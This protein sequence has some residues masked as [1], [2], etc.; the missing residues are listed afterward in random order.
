ME[1]AICPIC[2]EPN[3]CHREN[4]LDPDTCWCNTLIIDPKVFELVPPEA[5]GKACIC[6]A[7]LAAYSRKIGQN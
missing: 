6:P 1:K 5:L 4:G 3:G 2:H 7:C